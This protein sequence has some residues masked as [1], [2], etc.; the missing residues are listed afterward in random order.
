MVTLGSTVAAYAAVLDVID[1]LRI[2]SRP[3][4]DLSARKSKAALGW[5]LGRSPRPSRATLTQPNAARPSVRPFPLE[6]VEIPRD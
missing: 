6:R 1:G 3:A 4:A 5:C 2:C